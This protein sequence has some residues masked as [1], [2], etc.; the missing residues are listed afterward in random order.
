M[1]YKGIDTTIGNK[2]MTTGRHGKISDFR[3]GIDSVED[4]KERFQ[5]YCVANDI[6]TDEDKGKA[7]F[8][9]CVGVTT[10]NLLKN[11]VRPQKP[12]DL[13]LDELL[14]ALQK[15]YQP[16]I[17][18]IAERY[19]FYKRQQREGESIAV[20]QSELHRLAKDCQF[21][22]SLSIALSD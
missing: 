17:V 5:L 2:D 11:L 8:L 22:D 10:Y 21:G 20:Y 15:H 12:Q 19:R 4:Y 13:S 7:V 18:V 14:K 3:P 6:L 1:S 16:R 9:T